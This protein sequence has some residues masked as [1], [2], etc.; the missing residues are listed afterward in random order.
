VIPLACVVAIGI[1]VLVS[2]V[3]GMGWHREVWRRQL[4]ESRVSYRGEEAEVLRAAITDLHQRHA[5]ELSRVTERHRDEIA[6]LQ[7]VWQTQFAEQ[8]PAKVL[9]EEPDAEQRMLQALA[10]DEKRVASAAIQRG[11]AQILEDARKSGVPVSDEEAELLA[12]SMLADAGFG[13]IT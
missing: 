7:S 10:R 9:R 1:A 11:K 2:L 4:A 6:R 12:R 5:E 3:F 8:R 13:G